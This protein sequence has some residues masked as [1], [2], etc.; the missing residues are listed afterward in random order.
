MLSLFGWTLS[1]RFR[2]QKKT[3]PVV[4][5]QKLQDSL[6][7]TYSQYNEDIF[8]WQ[9]FEGKKS[10]YYVDIGA[11][12]PI[13]LSNTKKFYDMGWTGVTVEPNPKL[14]RRICEHRTRDMNLNCGVGD[15]PGK[16]TFYEIDPDC[17]STFDPKIAKMTKFSSSKK[18]IAELPIKII[19]INEIFELCKQ[20]VDFLSLDTENFDYKVLSV[21]DW[22]KNRPKV[23]V[24]EL[25]HD[26]DSK[27][28]ELLKQQMYELI[29]FNG[30]N[31]I[32][33]AEEYASG[34][35]APKEVA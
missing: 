34:F 2:L 30:T 15:V 13:K 21:N 8:L 7:K 29:F 6:L 10:G 5:N 26:E 9:L 22:S 33:V 11:N 23:I 17:Y 24:V 32:F 27:V 3:K 16:M 28:Y 18:V 14:Y 1:V 12:D 20:P 4:V 19:T 25:N 31:G 35:V